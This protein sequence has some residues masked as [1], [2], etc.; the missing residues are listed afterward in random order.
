MKIRLLANKID[1]IISKVS[2]DKKIFMHFIYV[3]NFWSD[4]ICWK[5]FESDQIA[6]VN[7]SDIWKSLKCKFIISIKLNIYEIV[8]S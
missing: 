2:K 1:E 8:N 5:T 7:N 4:R 3:E 6:Y